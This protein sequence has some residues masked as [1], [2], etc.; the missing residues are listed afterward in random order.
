MYMNTF[1]QGKQ[2]VV[3]VIYLFY[4]RSLCLNLTRGLLVIN[5]HGCIY[6][7]VQKLQYNAQADDANQAFQGIAND[8]RDGAGKSAFFFVWPF[9]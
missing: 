9:S 1:G 5:K 8:K 7:T 3:I 2:L 6:C 4:L